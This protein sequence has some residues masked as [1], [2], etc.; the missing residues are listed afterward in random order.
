MNK[1]KTNILL[2]YPDKELERELK[3]ILSKRETKVELF[4]AK[5]LDLEILSRE[6]I[7]LVLVNESNIGKIEKAVGALRRSID[8]HL[9]IIGIFDARIESVI[10]LSSELGMNDWII[11]PYIKQELENRVGHYID[12]VQALSESNNNKILFDALLHNV[13]YMS[14]FKN[15]ESQYMKVNKAFSEHAGKD[16]KT[17]KGR[18][19]LFVWDGNIG[20]RCREYDLKVMNERQHVIFNEV[21]SGTKGE[22]LFEVHKAPVFDEYDAVVGTVGVARDITEQKKIQ[23]KIEKLAYTDDLTQVRNRRGFYKYMEELR[24][25]GVKD[26]TMLYIDLDNFK[27]LND[28][29]GH[30]YGDKVLV[31]LANKL[32]KC[33]EGSMISR[34]GGDEFVIVFEG[35]R[36]REEV[37]RIAEA[38]GECTKRNCVKGEKYHIISAS[39]GIVQDSF[40]T[41]TIE[42]LLSKGD[43]ALYKAKENGKSQYVFYT[44]KLEEKYHFAME[45]EGAIEKAIREEEIVLYYQPQY[46]SDRK[47]MG[48]EALMR[49]ENDAYRHIPII[50]VIKIMEASNL[51]YAV[52]DYVLRRA[53]SFAKQINKHLEE[54][55]T[56]S[57]NISVLQLMEEN[58][59]DKIKKLIEELDV[60]PQL[61]GMEITETVLLEDIDKNME[62]IQE[63]KQIGITI[64]LDD[65]GTGYSSLNYLS[66]LPLCTIKIDKSFTEQMNLSDTHKYM[67]K[68]II[69]MAHLIGLT[70]VAEGIE[71]EEQLILL[72]DMKVDYIQGY[73]TGRPMK[74]KDV[75]KMI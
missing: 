66:K 3:E 42:Q 35:E 33:C 16:Y 21:I 52:G 19:D 71:D 60:K 6:N 36:P 61:I 34:L 31:E 49:W 59:V 54:K 30:Y 56:I 25:R 5:E 9:Q 8:K 70:V 37:A 15:K 51:I 22:R 47:L 10:A 69:Q 74:E 28:T 65:F 41:N 17:I 23:E 45:I 63:L 12:Y 39:I 1:K 73:L 24:E 32:K 68:T 7:K 44:H 67:V 26:I 14:W 29:Y 38:I 27:I 58:F 72:R 57:V 2:L 11:K 4:T 46:T 18:D 43:M 40:I 75:I 64:S 48:F 13:P 53:F 55:L 50:E 62:K 20:E